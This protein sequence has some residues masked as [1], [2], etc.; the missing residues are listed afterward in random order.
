MVVVVELVDNPK[1]MFFLLHDIL[2][3]QKPWFGIKNHE[4]SA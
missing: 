1:P 4:F 3:A 2:W